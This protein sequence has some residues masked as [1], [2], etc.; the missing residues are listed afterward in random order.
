MNKEELGKIIRN[1]RTELGITQEDLAEIC[2]IS[3][4]TLREIELGKANPRFET[5]LA[6]LATIGLSISLN[7]IVLN[8]A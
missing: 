1:R 7:A 8:H 3:S 5:L 6:I 4:K 2:S